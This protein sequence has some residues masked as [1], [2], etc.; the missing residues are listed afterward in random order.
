MKRAEVSDIATEFS[1]AE[2]GD[3]RRTRRLVKLVERINESPGASFPRLATSPS[4]LEAMYRF[5]SNEN[6]T[7]E[8]VL[9]PHINATIERC[10][11]EALVAVVH[12]T[13]EFS[14][15]TE[16]DARKDV[17]CLTQG[18]PGF[19]AHFALAVSVEPYGLPLGLLGVVAHK[20]TRSP[21]EKRVRPTTREHM[22]RE[23]WRKLAEETEQR[24]PKST[25]AVHVMDSE[26]DSYPIFAA[27]CSKDISFV[28]RGYHNRYLENGTRRL[29][30]VFDGV[31]GELFREVPVSPRR[32]SKRKVGVR[33]NVRRS[34]RKAS[35]HVKAARIVLPRPPTAITDVQ[36][37]ELS[38][39]KVYEPNPPAGQQPLEWML[40]TNLPID[41]AQGVARIID[42]YRARWTIEEYF[43]ALKTGCAYERRQLMS[44]HA[45]LNALAVLAPIAW[46]LLL[47]RHLA[48]DGGDTPASHL[49]LPDELRLLKLISRRV[50]LAQHPS[51]QDA[52]YAV[53]GLGG[54]LK[55]NGPPGWQTIWAGFT[56]L[57]IARMTELSIRRSDQS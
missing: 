11:D 35:L 24:M 16:D 5:F 10:A 27:L 51:V 6:V 18:H 34:G 43:K 33:S 45:L 3:P 4:E 19:E 2:L 25:K 13:S 55:N 21:K 15:N 29:N 30:D 57:R 53:A 17:G 1:T 40:L 20:R 32:G 39:V 48:R 28:I 38:I 36:Q 42:I 7:W 8:A 47:L 22:E 49:L 46:R 54:H 9:A 52:L 37:V 41:G 23:R 44:R 26:A 12:D 14:F 31:R 50:K 56:V